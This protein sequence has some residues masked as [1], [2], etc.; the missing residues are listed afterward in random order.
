M[1]IF[2]FEKTKRF[3]NGTEIKYFKNNISSL[4]CCRIIMQISDF[5]KE[6]VEVTMAGEVMQPNIIAGVKSFLEIAELAESNYILWCLFCG[7]F[8]N[9]PVELV[10]E[11]DFKRVRL[12]SENELVL[13]EIEAMWNNLC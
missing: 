11:F 3:E 5:N 4:D 2:T 10:V 12:I 8:R 1:D 7:K 9:S 6:R 13:K